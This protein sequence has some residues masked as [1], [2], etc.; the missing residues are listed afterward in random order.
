MQGLIDTLGAD[1]YVE[2]PKP[3][4]G[5][6]F[7]AVL[8]GAFPRVKALGYFVKPFHG[9]NLSFSFAPGLPDVASRS[10]N[11]GAKLSVPAV[12]L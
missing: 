9:G 10:L 7:R 12:L 2:G 4:F 5:R 6:P 1:R 8:M 11:D 3:D